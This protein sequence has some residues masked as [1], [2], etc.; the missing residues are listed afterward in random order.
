[1]GGGVCGASVG[2]KV[3]SM[4]STSHEPP[5]DRRARVAMGVTPMLVVAAFA[6]VGTGWVDFEVGVAVALSCAVW[7]VYELHACQREIDEYNLQALQDHGVWRGDAAD[8]MARDPQVD[9][10]FF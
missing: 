8:A 3:L 4:P 9:S 2:V 6:L 7:V 5:N 1:M 10:R